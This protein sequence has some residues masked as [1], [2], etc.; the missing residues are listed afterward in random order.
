MLMTLEAS[1]RWLLSKGGR[2]RKD[3]DGD[4]AKVIAVV[5]EHE[6]RRYARS[7]TELEIQHTLAEA[8]NALRRAMES[9]SAERERGASSASVRWTT[10][11]PRAPG[12]QA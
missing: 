5:G 7:R 4:G 10:R 8:I 2:W 9:H 1:L 6:A 3:D 12:R 11:E